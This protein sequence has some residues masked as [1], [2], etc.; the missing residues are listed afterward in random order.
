MNQPFSLTHS[1]HEEK[2]TTV[3][4]KK[5]ILSP[6]RSLSPPKGGIS[7]NIMNANIYIAFP[8]RGKGGGGN[9]L[10]THIFIS[11]KK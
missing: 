9:F 5:E 3:E 1:T 2:V 11:L 10:M 4:L 7:A 6:P 8:Q